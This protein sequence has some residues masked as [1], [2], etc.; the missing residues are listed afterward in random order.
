MSLVGANKD[1]EQKGKSQ[2]EMTDGRERGAYGTGTSVT[3]LEI[4]SHV[5]LLSFL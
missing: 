4:L 2:V 3:V 5:D 1:N